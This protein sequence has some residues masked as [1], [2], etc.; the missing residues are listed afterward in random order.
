M[1][2]RVGD[3]QVSSIN[4]VKKSIVLLEPVRKIIYYDVE[5]FDDNDHCTPFSTR[6]EAIDYAHSELWLRRSTDCRTS[7]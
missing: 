3:G 5:W 4:I 2:K 6:K 1:R 7:L